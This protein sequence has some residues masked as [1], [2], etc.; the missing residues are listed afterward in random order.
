[1]KFA[2]IFALFVS[3]SAFAIGHDIGNGEG[4]DPCNPDGARYVSYEIE[5]I[6]TYAR[7]GGQLTEELIVRR[8]Y[9]VLVKQSQGKS[10]GAASGSGSGSG[11]PSDDDC[12]FREQSAYQRL[13]N[14]AR[15]SRLTDI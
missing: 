3:S 9:L 10:S 15:D 4:Y 5:Q 11:S 14:G 8:E 2:V 7:A 6:D 13:F 12:R 1:M